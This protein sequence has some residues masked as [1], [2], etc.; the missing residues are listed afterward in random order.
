MPK[1]SAGDGT[2]RYVEEIGSGTPLVFVQ[3]YAGD[4]RSIAGLRTSR[5]DPIE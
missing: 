3:D 4:H 5:P 2:R 1:I